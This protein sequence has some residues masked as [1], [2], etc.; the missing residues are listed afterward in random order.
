MEEIITKK[1]HLRASRSIQRAGGTTGRWCSRFIK[2]LPK[3]KSRTEQGEGGG[4]GSDFRIVFHRLR[5]VEKGH[6][7]PSKT[8]YTPTRGRLSSF[9]RKVLASER[10]RHFPITTVRGEKKRLKEKRENR[11]A[12]LYIFQTQM[13]RQRSREKHRTKA[14]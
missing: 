14:I 5:G 12:Y 6:H 7:S 13:R 4:G 3:R 9:R 10:P 1:K 8:A 2:Y 11:L